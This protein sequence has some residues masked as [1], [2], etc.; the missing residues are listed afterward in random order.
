MSE[1][2][3]EGEGVS[4]AVVL[5]VSDPDFARSVTLSHIV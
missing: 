3:E 1:I 2:R 5:I 4:N